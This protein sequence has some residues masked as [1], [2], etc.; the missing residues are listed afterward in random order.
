MIVC[1][2]SFWSA[3]A[4]LWLALAIVTTI[5]LVRIRQSL[6]DLDN[7]SLS[8]VFNKKGKVIGIESTLYN[9]IKAILTTEILGFFVAA[10]AALS[11]IIFTTLCIPH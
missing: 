8:G 1:I 2:V 11:P 6:S 4:L 5:G 3:I 7:R 10:V 9:A